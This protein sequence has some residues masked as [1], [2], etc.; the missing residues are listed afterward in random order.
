MME[1]PLVFQVCHKFDGPTRIENDCKKDEC[2][3]QEPLEIAR[4]PLGNFTLCKSK[5][6]PQCGQKVVPMK[7]KVWERVPCETC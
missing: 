4:V 6:E 7:K 5:C 3:E 2:A 1:D